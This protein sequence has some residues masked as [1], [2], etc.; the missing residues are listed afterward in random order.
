MLDI[1]AREPMTYTDAKRTDH[2]YLRTP[3]G[4]T[5]FMPNRVP[6][7]GAVFNAG[8]GGQFWDATKGLYIGEGGRMLLS[9]GIG[10]AWILLLRTGVF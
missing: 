1:L 7:D 3:D 5:R 2:G 4:K 6:G 8:I 10:F 9:K